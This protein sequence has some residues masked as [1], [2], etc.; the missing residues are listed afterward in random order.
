MGFTDLFFGKTSFYPVI[1]GLV[2]KMSPGLGRNPW[3]LA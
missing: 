1:P 2:A 3:R